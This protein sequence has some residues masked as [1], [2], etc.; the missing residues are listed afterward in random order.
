MN[1][2]LHHLIKFGMQ[3]IIAY[4]GPYFSMSF[5]IALSMNIS[6]PF[7]IVFVF[8]SK[9]FIIFWRQYG[10][11]RI[12][13]LLYNLNPQ[14]V[15]KFPN[16]FFNLINIFEYG[17]DSPSPFC[18]IGGVPDLATRSVSWGGWSDCIHHATMVGSTDWEWWMRIAS[19]L[20]VCGVLPAPFHPP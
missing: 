3:N 9:H 5:D 15:I 17:T 8:F 20:V 11:G 7:Y 12:W 2:T 19:V 16:R 14:F 6:D 18:W 4:L 13:G 10:K 1:S